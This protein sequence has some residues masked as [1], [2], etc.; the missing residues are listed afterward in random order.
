MQL[1]PRKQNLRVP[2]A[3]SGVDH[4]G[5]DL[6]VVANEVGRIAVVRDDAADFGGGDEHVVGPLADEEAIDRCTVPQ[7]ERASVR[8]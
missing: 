5:L 7:I 4:V 6:E 2:A 8:G 3:I 1:D